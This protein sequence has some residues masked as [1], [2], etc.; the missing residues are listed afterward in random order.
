M[1][2]FQELESMKKRIIEISAN[3]KERSQNG[4]DYLIIE[5]AADDIDTCLG[6]IGLFCNDN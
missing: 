6:I 4:D 1:T 3:I 2:E 5:Q